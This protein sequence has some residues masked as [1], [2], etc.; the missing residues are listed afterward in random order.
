MVP[1][2]PT[3]AEGAA[4]LQSQLLELFLFL[5]SGWIL[6]IL[7]ALSV[8]SIAITIERLWH[9]YQSREDLETLSVGL[10]ERLQ[11][12][13]LEGARNLLEKSRSHVARVALRGL[14]GLSRGP[15][16]VEEIV[17]GAT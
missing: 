11:K 1:P 8:I 2:M 5:G 7:L 10:D 12:G 17:A 3:T 16:A 6:Y 15:D 13:E 4:T 14:A 9:F